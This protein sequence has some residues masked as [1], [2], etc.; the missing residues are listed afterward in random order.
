[1]SDGHTIPEQSGPEPSGTDSPDGDAGAVEEAAGFTADWPEAVSTGDT[2][3]DAVLGALDGVGG[4]PVSAHAELYSSVHDALLAE[5]K[6]D[7]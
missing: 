4:R 6:A 7:G 2:A 1:M 3:V 5:L